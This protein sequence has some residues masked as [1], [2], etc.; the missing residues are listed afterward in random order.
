MCS[1]AV[2]LFLIIFSM[3]P[4]FAPMA[5]TAGSL[6]FICGIW[7]GWI[8]K[9]LRTSFFSFSSR[10]SCLGTSLWSKISNTGKDLGSS[11]IFPF[12]F[13][14]PCLAACVNRPSVMTMARSRPFSSK[15]LYSA[16]IIAMPTVASPR[17]HQTRAFSFSLGM[18]TV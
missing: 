6:D 15:S 5:F 14:A 2:A 10:I 17:M 8:L 4:G 1:P 3:S 7:Y 9:R 13:L 16:F 11:S 12:F 18:L